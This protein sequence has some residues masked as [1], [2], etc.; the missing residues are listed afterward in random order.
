MGAPGLLYVLLSALPYACLAGSLWYATLRPNAR[1]FPL[2]SN[3]VTGALAYSLLV[4][5]QTNILSFCD[6]LSFS[7]I[8]IFWLAYAAVLSYLIYARKAFVTKPRLSGAIPRLIAIIAACAF[9][10]AIAYAPNNWDALAYH[11]PRVTHWLQNHNLAPYPTSIPR[12][13]G[14]PPFNSVISLQSLAMNGGDYFV[15]LTQWFAFVGVI[16]G[17]ARIGEQ[18]G[19]SKAARLYAALFVATLPSAVLQA[20][21]AES[22]D[23]VTFWILAFVSLFLEWR[24]NPT[25]AIA[26][27]LGACLGFAALSK[28]SA[29]PIALP[30]VLLV[31]WDCLKNF[32]TLFLKGLA[33]AFMV[34][35]IN[36]PQIERSMVAYD[37]PFGGAEK[38]IL[39]RPSPGSFLV[40]GLYGFLLH[41]PWLL[42]EPLI[43]VWQKTASFLGVSG[44]DKEIFP[45]GDINFAWKKF[46]ADDAFA[47][48]TLQALFLAWLFW[49]VLSRKFSPPPLYTWLVFFSFAGFFLLLTWHPFAGR[50]QTTLFA[51]AAPVAG[52]RISSIKKNLTRNCLLGAFTVWAFGV[53][54]L[55]MN[56][57]NPFDVKTN[58]FLYHTRLETYFNSYG[59]IRRPYVRAALFLASQNPD[60]VGLKIVDDG[61]EY[62]LWAILKQSVASPPRLYHLDENPDPTNG[63]KYVF[64]IGKGEGDQPLAAPE[65]LKRVG[66][67]YARVFPPE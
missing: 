49:L 38:N 21:N 51:L 27:K 63:P 39:L 54:A 28:G 60:E 34:I 2:F 48:N 65:V 11:L 52:V 9:V 44:S 53:L 41:E 3:L 56:P 35:L 14:M 23:L 4:W 10:V 18:L 19:A 40:N 64:S 25:L 5:T 66:G 61:L 59:T 47:Q 29:Y 13:I 26:L 12:Q 37:S 30:F 31:A 58:N 43:P 57:L 32:R 62:P 6:S 50:I 36:A 33:A 20:S 67:E 55:S 22:C 8:L 7:P 15:N 24:K 45:F 17:V 1:N 46:R 16:L 42:K